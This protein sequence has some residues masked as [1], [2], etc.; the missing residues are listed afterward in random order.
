[1]NLPFILMLVVGV[2]LLLLV[3]KVV[4][5][6]LPAAFAFLFWLLPLLL[7]V[8]GLV[9][10]IT[11]QKPGS[12][13]VLWVLVIVLAPLLGPLLWFFWGKNHT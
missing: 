11:S 12:L 6:L 8:A 4:L 2:V 1:M 9:S 13:K 5:T 3:A 7:T 10:C